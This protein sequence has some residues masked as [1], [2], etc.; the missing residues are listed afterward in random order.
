MSDA[1]ARKRQK[2]LQGQRIDI[3]LA[4]NPDAAPAPALA[5]FPSAQPPAKT[6]F[7]LYTPTGTPADR[8]ALLAAET[9]EIELESRNHLGL[10]AGGEDDGYSTQYM[11]GVRNPRTNTLTLHA[12]PLHTF[13]PSIKSLKAPEATLDSAAAALYTAQRSALGTA[14]G[15]KK[16]QAQQRAQERNK[17]TESSFGTGA[18]VAGLQSHLQQSISAKAGALPSA[19]DIEAKANEARPIP[20]FNA[21]ATSPGDVYPLDGVVS[22]GELHALDLSALVAAPDFKA[23]LQLLPY[24]RSDWI[25]TK[26]RQLLPARASAEGHVA[27]PSKKDRDRL[28]LVVY[29]AHLFQFRQ[30]ARPGRPVDRA[31]VVEKLGAGGGGASAALVDALI[32]RFTEPVRG[33]GHAGGE[34]RT[35]TSTAEIKCLCY[36]LVLMLR[37]D[38]WN[39][40][41]TTVAEDLGM[42]NKR[43]QELFRS[44]GCQLVA[45]SAADREK[46]VAQGRATSAADAAKSKKASLKVPLQFPKERRGKAKR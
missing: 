46:L 24:R 34:E 20:P 36:M 41:V 2:G 8:Q 25:R 33:G 30:A 6:P 40:D 38:G 15:T 35:V 14:F 16:A 22:A 7:T 12:A 19:A 31:H 32:E 43:V 13:T 37:V 42:G 18:H 26:L 5:L 17:L 4:P 11:I 28:R 1:S 29:L 9:D 39:T 3:A 44:L 10:A 45:P 21:A 23:R 27:N